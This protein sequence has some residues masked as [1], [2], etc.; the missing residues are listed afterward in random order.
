MAESSSLSLREQ[1]ATP[2]QQRDRRD[3]VIVH[4]PAAVHSPERPVGLRG[5]EEKLH[6]GTYLLRVIAF[7]R[8]ISGRHK[9]HQRIACDC[10]RMRAPAAFLD[11]P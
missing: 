8:Q 3:A 7:L 1:F 4:V 5:I 10:D 9:R 6:P 11:G 2:E